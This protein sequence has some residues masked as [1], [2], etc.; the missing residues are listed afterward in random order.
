[1]VQSN[2]R[3]E[4]PGAPEQFQTRHIENIQPQEIKN[5]PADLPKEKVEN[6]LQEPVY[7]NSVQPVE[8]FDREIVVQ[9]SQNE[10][11]ER[12][13]ASGYFERNQERVV[14][15]QVKRLED[16]EPAKQSIYRTI[17]P[18]VERLDDD[19]ND[20]ENLLGKTERSD[21]VA[22]EKIPQQSQSSPIISQTQSNTLLLKQLFNLKK[23]N[24]IKKFSHNTTNTV[25]KIMKKVLILLS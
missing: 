23:S 19:D 1:M 25:K 15:H 20:N 5:Q 22:S 17:E 9:S 14:E 11:V 4:T 10:F 24:K 13:A 8:R 3:I 12:P 18:E 7:Q 6:K 21:H 16:S 2:E